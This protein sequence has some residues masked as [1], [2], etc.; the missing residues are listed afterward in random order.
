VPQ[1]EEE[2]EEYILCNHF[3]LIYDSENLQQTQMTYKEGKSF[4][5]YQKDR[6]NKIL[7]LFCTKQLKN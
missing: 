5:V 6:K 4:V 1:E 3:L 7:V 2:E